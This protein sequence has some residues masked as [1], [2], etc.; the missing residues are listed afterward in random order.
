M[1]CVWATR[2]LIE[3]WYALLRLTQVW[4][5]WGDGSVGYSV[6]EY[7]TFKRHGVPIIALVGND[8][9]WS[10]I[11][12]D[13][14]PILG[15]AQHHTHGNLATWQSSEALLRTMVGHTSLPKPLTRLYRHFWVAVAGDN[16]ACPLLYTP[17]E[18]VA[19]GYGGDGVC[20][21]AH[22]GTLTSPSETVFDCKFCYDVTVDLSL[23]S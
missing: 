4:L 14:V 1:F 15:T 13:Q 6:A 22:D 18:D 19:R 10:Q 20:I 11:E 8:A 17:Y 7:D 9:C 12:R 2:M 16:V 3:A 23:F 5:L 21:Q